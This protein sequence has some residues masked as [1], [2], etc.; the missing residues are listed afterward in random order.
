MRYYVIITPRY[1][2]EGNPFMTDRTAIVQFHSIEM[3]VLTHISLHRCVC[4]PVCHEEQGIRYVSLGPGL[5]L[6]SVTDAVRSD[7]VSPCHLRSQ[8]RLCMC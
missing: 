5:S 2:G 1:I 8:E 4:F 7:L 6:C 3:R